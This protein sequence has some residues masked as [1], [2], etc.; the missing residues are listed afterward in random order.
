MFVTDLDDTLYKEF[1]F[2]HSAFRNIAT[3]VAR[4]GLIGYDD[5]FEILSNAPG[6]YAGFEELSLRCGTDSFSVERMKEIYRFHMPDI[7]LSPGVEETL[8][9]IK[10]KG[11]RIGIITDGRSLT[12][13]NKI[14]ALGLDRFVDD[15]DIIISQETGADKDTPIPF[16]KIMKR[17]PEEKRFIYV[18]DNPKK[19]FHHPNLLGWETIM[20]RDPDHLNVH[21]HS[22]EFYPSDFKA[23]F[24]ID[25]FPEILSLI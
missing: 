23:Q 18:G 4:E 15:R 1:D 6:H 13:R 16:R 17:N 9:A 2:V 24:A 19:D 8:I 5:A 12:Q 25:R 20:L 7:S 3:Q 14:K 21:D 10:E 22:L 11:I